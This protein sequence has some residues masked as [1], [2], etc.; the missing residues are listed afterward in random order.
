[1][2]GQ[3]KPADVEMEL[4]TPTPR[5][6]HG[7]PSSTSASGGWASS[8]VSRWNS[9]L[10]PLAGVMEGRVPPRPAEVG[11]SALVSRWN[12]TLPPPA[13]AMEGRV[14]PRPAEVGRARRCRD[15]T[16]H[17]HPSQVPWRAEFH[18]GH[19]GLG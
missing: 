15:G 13:D 11:V 2:G 8:P 18:L 9:T 3:G 10:P 17:S 4:D 12:S 1:S 19:P 6:R 16:R 7:G 5:R 14:P